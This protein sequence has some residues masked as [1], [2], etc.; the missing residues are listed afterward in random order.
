MKGDGNFR[1][2][3]ATSEEFEYGFGS[4]ETR[5][6]AIAAG[7]ESTKPGEQFWIAEADKMVA[8]T[9]FFDADR[10]LEEFGE[11]NEECWGEDGAEDAITVSDHMARDL[12]QMLGQAFDAWAAKHGEPWRVW[13]FGEMRNEECVTVPANGEPS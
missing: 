3:W 5:E 1:W 8:S 2:F 6:Q 7:T 12:E 11:A 13:A 4:F 10:V 9:R